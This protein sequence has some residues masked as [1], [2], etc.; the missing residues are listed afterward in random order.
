MNNLPL[1]HAFPLLI[2]ALALLLAGCAP[3]LPVPNK[4]KFLV[5]DTYTSILIYRG[6]TFKLQTNIENKRLTDKL[7]EI[8]GGQDTIIY[9]EVIFEH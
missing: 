2:L 7:H 1:R 9:T 4:V 5:G 8:Y 6:G 3:S